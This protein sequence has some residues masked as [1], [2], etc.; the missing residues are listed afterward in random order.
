M[1]LPASD[2]LPTA[3]RQNH[4]AF[5]LQGIMCRVDPGS[6]PCDS[7]SGHFGNIIGHFPAGGLSNIEAASGTGLA[8]HHDD[9][10]PGGHTPEAQKSSLQE[11]RGNRHRR[12]SRLRNKIG[13]ASRSPLKG[14]AFGARLVSQGR[15]ARFIR[16]GSFLTPLQA[17]LRERLLNPRKIARTEETQMHERWIEVVDA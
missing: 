10:W 9:G 13:G 6:F 4:Q 8:L 16:A 1:V 2:P 5:D 11:L 3:I 14:L 17:K 7:A 12:R 15:P